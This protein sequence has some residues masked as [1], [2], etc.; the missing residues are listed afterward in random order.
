MKNNKDIYVVGD[1]TYCC[2]YKDVGECSVPLNLKL[3]L[4]SRKLHNYCLICIS[5][6]YYGTVDKTCI[7][8]SY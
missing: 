8:H 7:S 5:Y 2:I 6:S 3:G 1:A 4:F